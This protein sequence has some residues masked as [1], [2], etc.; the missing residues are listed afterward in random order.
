M[1]FI[2][3][4]HNLE[5]VRF[6]LN[7]VRLA[8]RLQ[9]LDIDEIGRFEDRE[10]QFEKQSALLNVFTSHFCGEYVMRLAFNVFC[11]KLVPSYQ[12]HSP[13]PIPPA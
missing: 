13:A 5:I 8:S 2:L 7:N 12:R 11:A 10:L 3:P 1:L 6:V 9:L 4:I